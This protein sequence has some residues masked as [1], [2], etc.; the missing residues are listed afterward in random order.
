MKRNNPNTDELFRRGERRSDGYFFWGYTTKVKK[1][2]TYVE[3]WLHPE[4]YVSM[5][6][7]ALS[8]RMAGYVRKSGRAPR[9]SRRLSKEELAEAMRLVSF[10]MEMNS[11]LPLSDED[12][13]FL[14]TG[15]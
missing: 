10:Q 2:G 14:L 13:S 5:R 7:K 9:N 1:D 4:R 11:G 12:K 3:I 15:M 8:A 6:N